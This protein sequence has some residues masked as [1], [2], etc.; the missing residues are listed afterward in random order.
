MMVQIGLLFALM[1]SSADARRMGPDEGT[2][3]N[4]A[5]QAEESGLRCNTQKLNNGVELPEMA[6][7]YIRWHP[8]LAWGTPKLVDVLVTATEELAWQAPHADP[9]VIGDMSREGGGPLAGHKSHRGG[10]DADVGIFWG[11]GKQH[12]QGF[13]RID[14]T[15]IDAQT[16][17]LFIESMIATGDVERILLDQSLIDVLKHHVI[18]TGQL[19]APEAEKV[20]P[21]PNEFINMWGL[22]RVVHHLDGHQNHLHIRVYCDSPSDS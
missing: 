17:W 19:T 18:T 7:L 8:E 12:L 10:L 21:T 15:M 4:V 13:N 22:Q 5:P 2:V 9:V 16:T 6:D 1:I 11:N 14:P 20:F 3:L